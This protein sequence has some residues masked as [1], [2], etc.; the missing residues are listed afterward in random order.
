MLNLVCANQISL[1]TQIAQYLLLA[2][3][4]KLLIKYVNQAYE[5]LSNSII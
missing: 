5:F 3:F 2:E 1:T 4:Q